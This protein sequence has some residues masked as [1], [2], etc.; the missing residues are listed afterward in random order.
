[1]IINMVLIQRLLN[2]NKLQ[3]NNKEKKFLSTSHNKVYEVQEK[4]R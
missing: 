3:K 2:Q 4:V 1:M